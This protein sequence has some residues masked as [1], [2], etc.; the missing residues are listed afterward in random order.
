MNT[1]LSEEVKIKEKLIR[2]MKDNNKN[3]TQDDGDIEDI[4]ETGNRQSEKN[5]SKNF[6]E[7]FKCNKC[8][9]ETKTNKHKICA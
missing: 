7:S 6:E 1:L 5:K 2:T 3:T 9:Y 4:N 8:D